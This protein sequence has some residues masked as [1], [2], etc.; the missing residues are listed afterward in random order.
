MPARLAVGG[1]QRAAG[2]AG[3][4][5]GVGLDEELIVAGADLGAR[6]RRDDAHGHGLADAEGIADRQHQVAH[7]H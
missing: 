2:I 7:L 1:H 3:I 6:Q 5:G 4:D